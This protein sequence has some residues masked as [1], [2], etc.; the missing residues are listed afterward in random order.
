MVCKAHPTPMSEFHAIALKGRGDLKLSVR[1]PF[2]STS[3]LG[4]RDKT[5]LE[6][7]KGQV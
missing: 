7:Y 1:A 3:G 6:L 2:Y 5:S 4:L